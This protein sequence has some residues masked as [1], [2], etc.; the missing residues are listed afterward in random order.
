MRGVDGHA[1]I[2]DVSGGGFDGGKGGR[3]CEESG[4]RRSEGVSKG[5][6]FIGVIVPGDR[7]GKGRHGR[8]LD[9]RR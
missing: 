4:R 1:V 6:C 7:R 2:I 9:R 3:A 5:R 8:A